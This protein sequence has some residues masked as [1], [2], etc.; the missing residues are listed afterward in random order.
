MV[1][2]PH[3]SE[4]LEVRPRQFWRPRYF[5]RGLARTGV[6]KMTVPTT[7][8]MTGHQHDRL[9]QLLFPGDGKEAVAIVLCGRRDGDRRH[10][11]VVRAIEEIPSR[12][13]SVRTPI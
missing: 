10:R 13:C 11:L 9:K 3:T 5:D 2:P 7:L 4:P 1:P 6:Q 12:A 8:S